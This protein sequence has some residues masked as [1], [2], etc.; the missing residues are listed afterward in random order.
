M[1]RILWLSSAIPE[2]VCRVLHMQEGTG[3]SWLN[4][5]AALLDADRS[6]K[7]GICS[8]Y[9]KGKELLRTGW[10]KDSF[11]Y[12]FQR[13][14]YE[15]YQYDISLEKVFDEVIKEFQPDIV[16]IFGTEF[17]HTLSMV[18]AFNNPDRT[19]IHIQGLISVIAQHYDSFLP[20]KETHKA[21]FRDFMRRDNIAGQQRKFWLRGKFE[22][23]AIRRVNHVMGRTDWDRACTE[24]MHPGIK[25]HYVQEMMRSAFYESDSGLPENSLRTD[26]GENGSIWE[27][28]KCEKYSICM[29]QGSYPIKG[30][31]MALKTLKIL[32]RKYRNVKLY[33]AGNDIIHRNGIQEKI[34]ESYYGVYIEKKIKEYG[35]DSQVVFTGPLDAEGM[36]KRYLKSHVFLSASSIENSPNSVGEAMLL[37]VPAVS[38]YVGGVAS[39]IEHGKNGFLYQADA[40]YM[41][42][43]YIGMIF[44]D[45]VLA[46]N[47][48]AAEH[49]RA[50]KLYNREE[51]M[52]QLMGAYSEMCI[53]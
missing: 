21:T 28:K 32:K 34:R 2:P 49:E 31:H 44:G 43:Y 52:G 29:S 48:S 18:K 10:G 25:Y 51:I 22:R 19:V 27:L 47:M 24:Q 30:L 50:E 39:L 40:P 9:P 23:D 36:K 41:A 46:E 20:Y 8:P 11:F 1:M 38:S 4:Q 15:N 12:G 42:A 16:H 53:V 45:D 3:Q 7:L 33:I 26:A 13:G 14:V 35:L 37:G 6:V 5:L 17:P